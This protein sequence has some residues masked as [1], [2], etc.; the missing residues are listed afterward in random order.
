MFRSASDSAARVVRLGCQLRQVAILVNGCGTHRRIT[1][2]FRF[3][4]AANG[5]LD[6]VLP[7]LRNAGSFRCRHALRQRLDAPLLIRGISVVGTTKSSGA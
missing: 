5:G 2:S 7:R 6:G 4:D 1:R 3:G